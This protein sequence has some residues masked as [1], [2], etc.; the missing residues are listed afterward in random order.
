MLTPWEQKSKFNNTRIYSLALNS[1]RTELFIVSD[2]SGGFGGKDIYV[3]R[4]ESD[5]SFWGPLEN[6]GPKVNSAYDEVGLSLSKDDQSLYFSSNNSNSIGG[7]DVFV[8]HR[9]NKVSWSAPTNL[10]VPI[11]TP[12]DDLFFTFLNSGERACY[13]NVNK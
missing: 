3:T 10:G 13:T 6:L 8:S 5:T 4:R 1:S 9:Q 12:T 2:R 7:F 11:N